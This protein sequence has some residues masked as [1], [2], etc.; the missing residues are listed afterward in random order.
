[1]RGSFATLSPLGSG[2][3]LVA[4]GYDDAIDLR[5]VADVITLDELATS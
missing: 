2:D 1:M 5:R 3:L 4:G